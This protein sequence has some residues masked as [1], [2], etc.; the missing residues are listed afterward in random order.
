MLCFDDSD[1]LVDKYDD[2]DPLVDKDL[3]IMCHE[4]KR[5]DD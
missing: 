4:K 3:V 1:Q 2:T 5:G